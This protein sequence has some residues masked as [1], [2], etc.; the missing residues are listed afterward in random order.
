MK[1]FVEFNVQA[2]KEIGLW[3]GIQ[4]FECHAHLK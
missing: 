1:S 4:H 2:Q 3:F